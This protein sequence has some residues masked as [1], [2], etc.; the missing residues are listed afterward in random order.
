LANLIPNIQSFA[1]AS[2]SGGYVFEIIERKSKID[3]FNNDG[4]I[5]SKFIGDIEFKDIRFTY[6]SRQ[7]ASVNNS[8]RFFF[9]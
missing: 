8:F 2:G 3:I 6:P 5:P 1:E 7:D 4:E 9:Y